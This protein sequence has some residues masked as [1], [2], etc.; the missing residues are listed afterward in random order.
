MCVSV[1]VFPERVSH[2]GKAHLHVGGTIPWDGDLGRTKVEK[3]ERK[4]FLLPSCHDLNDGQLLPPPC[5]DGLSLLNCE[6]K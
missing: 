3:G 2:P 4:A 1:R 6:P 5:Y